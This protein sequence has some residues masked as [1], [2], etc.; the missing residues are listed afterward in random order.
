MALPD[1]RKGARL[2]FRPWLKPE[3]YDFCQ[4]GFLVSAAEEAPLVCLC[5]RTGET[6][7][8]HGPELVIPTL[9]CELGSAQ[10]PK[11]ELEHPDEVQTPNP[12]RRLDRCPSV[13]C[14]VLE[15]T[16]VS[17]TILL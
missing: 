1:R 8:F 16:Y 10:L 13:T 7:E 5:C 15:R 12:L 11:K 3:F 4:E 9:H 6:P 14:T 17:R 2:C